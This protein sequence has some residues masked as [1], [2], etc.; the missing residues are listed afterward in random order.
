MGR[1]YINHHIERIQRAIETEKSKIAE[2]RENIIS[3]RNRKKSR[4]ESY[5]YLIKST[6]SRGTKE[7]LRRSKADEWK[8][9]S[10]IIDREKEKMA[11]SRE[12]ISEYRE[13]LKRERD[14]LK[15][16]WQNK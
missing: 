9:F 4:A 1:N 16:H 5:S 2:S 11:S 12:R 13:E 15:N 10:R 6:A 3:T 7:N 14:K 8:E